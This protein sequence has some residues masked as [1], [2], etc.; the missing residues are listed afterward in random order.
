MCMKMMM[1]KMRKNKN[2]YRVEKKEYYHANNVDHEVLILILF[3]MCPIL[4]HTPSQFFPSVFNIFFLGDNR[5]LPLWKLSCSQTIFLMQSYIY[6]YIIKA[7]FVVS[8]TF[9][10]LMKAQSSDDEGP[11]REEEEALKL[12]R[13]K[14]K[15]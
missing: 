10:F 3:A 5:L 11:L 15:S 2:L 13:Q 9:L 6:I 14:E 7:V 12:Q 8:L 4:I 1:K